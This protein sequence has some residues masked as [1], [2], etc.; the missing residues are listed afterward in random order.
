MR[1]KTK[2]TL[3]FA[4]LCLYFFQNL[5]VSS[6]WF[7]I[8]FTYLIIIFVALKSS[9][10]KTGLSATLIGLL[11]DF[12][13]GGTLGIYGFSRTLIAFIFKEV[14]AFIDLKRGFYVFLITSISLSIS[15]FTAN[16]LMHLI[17]DFPFNLNFILLQPIFTG[18]TAILILNSSYL[19]KKLDV[20]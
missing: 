15:N 17:S 10:F 5:Y 2:L 16:F 20:Y 7:S 6:S 13:S 14:L 11:I 18:L 12:I 1:G 9:T 3:T 19:K 8:D 4:L